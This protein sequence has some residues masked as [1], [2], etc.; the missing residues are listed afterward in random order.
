MHRTGRTSSIHISEQMQRIGFN[1]TR[2][3]S[4]TFARK[5]KSKPTDQKKFIFINNFLIGKKIIFRKRQSKRHNKVHTMNT[6]VA[7][8]G[9]QEE[10]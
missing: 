4:H 3:E 1:L 2:L 10:K 8:K 5:L 9:K 7:K 6:F